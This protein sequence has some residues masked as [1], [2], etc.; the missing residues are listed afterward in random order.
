MARPD[1]PLTRNICSR[2]I[3]A[4]A[5]LILCAFCVTL[6]AGCNQMLT[7]RS[8]QLLK[9]ADARASDGDYMHAINLY[10]SALDGSATSADI[11]YKLAL[12]YDDKMN[13]PLNAMHHFK[14]Y[15]ALAPT[16]S[17][18]NEAKSFMKR[19]ELALLTSLSGDSV[20]TRAEAARLKN[21]NL[22]LRK[23]LEERK[24]QIRSAAESEKQSSG[25]RRAE[26]PTP[27]PKKGKSNRRSHLAASAETRFAFFTPVP[28]L[29]IS[30]NEMRE[31]RSSESTILRS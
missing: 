27:T 12:L 15:L 7:P 31:A 9:D 10:E 21:E 6:L 28:K 2:V 22:G 19:D 25:A 8:K 1:K 13:D 24:E 16:G 11:H 30:P 3:S 23:Q 17:R 20:V 29:R 4:S 18:A 5:P 14:R 26:K